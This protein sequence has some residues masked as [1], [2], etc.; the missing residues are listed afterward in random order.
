VSRRAA[1]AFLFFVVLAGAAAAAPRLDPAPRAAPPAAPAPAAA[2]EPTTAPCTVVA[3]NLFPSRSWLPPPPPPR[4]PEPPKAPPLPF[5]YMGQLQEEGGIALF[6]GRDK[7]TLIVRR[8]DL[9]E[10][11]YRVEDVTPLRATFVFLP[12]DQ[13]QHLT[14]R[15]RP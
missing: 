14:L 6:L 2:A 3:A 8:G 10:G 9:V 5:T 1:C 11:S 12:L 7:R 15:T 4:K 13:R